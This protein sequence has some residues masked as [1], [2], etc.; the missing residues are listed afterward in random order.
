MTNKYMNAW[1]SRK[2]DSQTCDDEMGRRLEKILRRI[3]AEELKKLKA[4]LAQIERQ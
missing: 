3:E 2:Q 4:R 1:S